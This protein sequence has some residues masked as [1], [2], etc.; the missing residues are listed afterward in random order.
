MKEASGARGTA[1]D[2]TS[3]CSRDDAEAGGLTMYRPTDWIP[4]LLL[5]AAVALLP[6]WVVGGG[7]LGAAVGLWI[8]S[9]RAADRRA[10]QDQGGG[11]TLPP[12]VIPMVGRRPQRTKG[13]DI[14]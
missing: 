7:A 13:D 10:H 8:G 12:N 4:P 1:G 5:L 14:V 3:R 11:Q 6:W 2:G 9:R